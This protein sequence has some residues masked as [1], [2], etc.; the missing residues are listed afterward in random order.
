LRLEQLMPDLLEEIRKDLKDRP[1]FR[2]FV[3]LKKIWNYWSSGDEFM[4]FYEDLPD[5]DN[6]LLIL[7]NYNLIRGCKPEPA[8]LIQHV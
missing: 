8:E 7:E 3:P 5:L 2:K 4:Y 6:K 1:L